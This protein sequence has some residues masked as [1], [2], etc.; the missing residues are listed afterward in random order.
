[1][2]YLREYHGNFLSGKVLK[3]RRETR[4]FTELGNGP[5]IL[6]NR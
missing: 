1:M 6:K 5:S 3:S 4:R 2:V